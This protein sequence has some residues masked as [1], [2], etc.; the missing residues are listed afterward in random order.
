MNVI[1][2]HCESRKKFKAKKLQQEIDEVISA[3]ARK[4]ILN[5]KLFTT[6]ELNDITRMLTGV[7]TL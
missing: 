2:K 6:E 5:Y 3:S 4:M 1:I 7:N